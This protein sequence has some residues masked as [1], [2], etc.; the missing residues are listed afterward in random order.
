MLFTYQD[1][2]VKLVWRWELFVIV[3]FVLAVADFSELST[4]DNGLHGLCHT[5]IGRFQAD[6]KL[7]QQRFIGQLYFAA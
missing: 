2:V 7:G 5:V 4:F 6:L 1:Q 3:R